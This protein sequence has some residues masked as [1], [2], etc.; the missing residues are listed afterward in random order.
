M[1]VIIKYY[2]LF[3]EEPLDNLVHYQNIIAMKPHT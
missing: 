2:Q 1:K 3:I